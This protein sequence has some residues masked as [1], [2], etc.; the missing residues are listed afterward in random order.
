[1][2]RGEK[3]SLRLVREADLNPLFDLHSDLTKRGDYFPLDLW[4]EAEL[5]QRYQVWEEERGRLLICVADQ[6]VGMIGF[7]KSVPYYD[8]L[9]IGYILFDV[10]SRN[11]GYMTEALSL[12]V[13]YLFATKKIN[14]L[15]LTLQVGNVASKRV[16][17]KCG[18]QFE[19]IAR[20]AVFHRGADRDL[21]MYSLLRGEAHVF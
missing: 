16:A 1:M 19:G 13:K 21:E 18:V 7:F 9:E 4:T 14:R 20:G 8:A 2:L 10:D 15:Q 17:E 12:L 3:I 11:K 5:K 6:I